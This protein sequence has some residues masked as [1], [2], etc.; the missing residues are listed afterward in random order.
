MLDTI[1][2]QFDRHENLWFVAEDDFVSRFT[3]SVINAG[4]MLERKF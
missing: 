4:I 3:S 2:S 1:E